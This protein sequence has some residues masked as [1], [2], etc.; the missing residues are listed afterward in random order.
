MPWDFAAILI[1]LAAAVP[2]LGRRRIRQLLAVPYTTKRDRLRLYF[3]TVL[4][5][6][7]A[8][9]IILWRCRA[10]HVSLRQLAMAVP[11]P[12]LAALVSVGLALLLV[13]NQILGV[14]QLASQPDKITGIMPKLALRI[15]PQD[16][17][18]R[19]CFVLVV[20]TVAFCEE[21]IY[22][23][24]VQWLFTSVTGGVVAIGIIGSALLFGLAHLYQGPRGLLVTSFLGLGFSLLRAWTGSL[25]P[26]V[27][28][29]FVADFAV[30]MLAPARLSAT[31]GSQNSS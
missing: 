19:A 5:Q 28:G 22:R 10:H 25:L 27:I 11:N 24:F 21:L 15:F 13:T 1:F 31:L 16:N 7:F 4:S 20:A 12:L 26:L 30:G 3:S 14:R 8:V 18:E 2:L 9:T 6:W 17:S 29:H 23:G